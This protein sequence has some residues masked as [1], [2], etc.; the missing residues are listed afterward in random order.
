MVD[1]T[2]T[3]SKTKYAVFYASCV[4][5]DFTNG[6]I[7]AYFTLG[8]TRYQ[9]E[10]RLNSFLNRTLVGK[11]LF[12]GVI[13][14]VN[15][16]SETTVTDT[17]SPSTS[18]HTTKITTRTKVPEDSTKKI[19]KRIV[20]QENNN[21]I[22]RNNGK[23]PS[24]LTILSST[25][26]TTITTTNMY[27]NTP[28]Q[29]FT[30]INYIIGKAVISTLAATTI[31]TIKD[32]VETTGKYHYLRR[33]D[34][35]LS[36]HE[37]TTFKSIVENYRESCDEI[38]KH[39]KLLNEYSETTRFINHIIKRQEIENKQRQQTMKRQILLSR[40]NSTYS[41]KDRSVTS[42]SYFSRTTA[43]NLFQP[44]FSRHKQQHPRAS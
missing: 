14:L 16:N 21:F 22:I 26:S 39:Q 7:V 41:F 3:D 33:A 4:V 1:T 29:I 24:I 31:K 25:A 44:I 42:D 11:T 27:T 13:I 18:K 32:S 20:M 30:T 35:Q 36:D 17:N 8:F 9:N 43:K 38:P 28:N 10:T 5:N 40:N 6:S 12:G 15:F 37:K 34:Q 2:L 19:V 23:Q